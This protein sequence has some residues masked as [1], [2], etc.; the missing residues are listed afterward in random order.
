MQVSSEGGYVGRSVA[1]MELLA[2]VIDSVVKFMTGTKE[3]TPDDGEIA[4]YRTLIEVKPENAL[5]CLMELSGVGDG[6]TAW[7]ELL[8]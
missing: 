2:R 1:I 7:L 4:T 5:R 3:G 6:R 8:A